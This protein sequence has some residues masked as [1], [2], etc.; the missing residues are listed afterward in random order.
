MRSNMGEVLTVTGAMLLALPLPLLPL[1]ILWVNLVTDSVPALALA[2]EPGDKTAMS[3][4]PRKKGEGIFTNEWSL[5]FIA[6]LLNA[7]ICLIVFFWIYHTTFDLPAARTATLTALIMYQM[8]LAFS[9]RTRKFVFFRGFIGN[10]WLIVAV[11]IALGLQTV[12][13]FTPLGGLM[14]LGSIQPLQFGVTV[15]LA[16]LAFIVFE[17]C[18]VLVYKSQDEEMRLA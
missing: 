2:A 17:G 1:H 8:L 14:S 7:V 18:K 6:G 4:P 9:V 15:G 11:L 16:L 12:L 10:S 5:L 13:L 3:R